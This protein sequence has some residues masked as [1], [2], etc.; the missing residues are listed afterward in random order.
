MTVERLCHLN[1]SMLFAV[2]SIFAPKFISQESTLGNPGLFDQFSAGIRFFLE[3]LFITTPRCLSWGLAVCDTEVLNL[4]QGSLWRSLHKEQIMLTGSRHYRR[5]LYPLPCFS[6]HSGSEGGNWN[7]LQFAARSLKC[8]GGQGDE[9]EMEPACQLRLLH[10]KSQ[11][12]QPLPLIQPG[13]Y[14]N[15]LTS[16]HLKQKELLLLVGLSAPD[17]KHVT[18]PVSFI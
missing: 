7:Y 11:F 6:L 5:T 4:P 16:L 18:L 10:P 1:N 12:F 9:C 15:R 14:V 8:K 13:K 17:L 3:G 2:Y